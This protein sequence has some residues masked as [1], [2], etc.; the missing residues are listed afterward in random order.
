MQH[1]CANSHVYIHTPM[2]VCTCMHTPTHV[3]SCCLHMHA[4][5]HMN[6]CQ[7]LQCAHTNSCALTH[8]GVNTHTHSCFPPPQHCSCLPLCSTDLE[9]LPFCPQGRGSTCMSV[10]AT[11]PS[12]T[13]LPAPS[14]QEGSD[15]VHG[16]QSQN[17]L[18]DHLE[19]D[20]RRVP[21]GG[22]RGGEG[23]AW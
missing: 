15:S 10:M 21:V 5:G 12:L 7:H 3:H 11:G 6:M 23:V 8:S 2:D 18:I 17:P 1:I 19:R 20:A 14:V 13:L 9:R 22:W 4:Q 16:G